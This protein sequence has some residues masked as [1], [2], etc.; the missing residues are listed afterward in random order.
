MYQQFFP[1]VLDIEVSTFSMKYTLIYCVLCFGELSLYLSSLCVIQLLI[2][3][4]S[5]FFLLHS[6][7]GDEFSSDVD[8]ELDK[9]LENLVTNL[10]H[11]TKANSIYS[12]PS[13]RC[14]NYEDSP[15]SSIWPE[16]GTQKGSDLIISG[17]SNSRIKS[18]VISNFILLYIYLY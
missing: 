9:S 17:T 1:E 18:Q 3:F 12:P 5:F 2:L 11:E 7:G 4:Y 16:Y 8:G 15:R 10:K 14:Q 13:T 6:Q